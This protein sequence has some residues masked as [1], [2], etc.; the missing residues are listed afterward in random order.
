[1]FAVSLIFFIST[2]LCYTG[3]GDRL[4]RTYGV[5]SS[6]PTS[7][8]QAIALGWKQTNKSCDPN[9]GI[10]YAYSGVVNQSYP[11]SVKLKTNFF[12]NLHKIG[13]KPDFLHTS[14]TNKWDCSKRMGSTYKKSYWIFLGSEL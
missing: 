10:E 5:Y 6:L 8:A 7:T 2:S 3:I 9:R 4:V 11:L 13:K 1:M 14:R 12:T